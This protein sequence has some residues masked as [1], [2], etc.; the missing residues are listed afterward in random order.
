[1][2]YGVDDFRNHPKG[3]A[4]CTCECWINPFSSA[5]FVFFTHMYFF[6]V[7]FDPDGFRSLPLEMNR[8]YFNIMV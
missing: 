3:T 5:Q 4:I 1:M 8:T 2:I 6:V 7:N